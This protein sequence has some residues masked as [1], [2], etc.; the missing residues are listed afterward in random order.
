MKLD[1]IT[2]LAVAVIQGALV[3]ILYGE[4]IH[5]PFLFDDINNITENTSIRVT[6]LT[7]S[8]LFEAAGGSRGIKSRGIA[9][10]SF[11]VNYYFHGTDVAGYHLVNMI[12]HL[13]AGIFLYL[14]LK[15][16][17]DLSLAAHHK[18]DS[19]LIAFFASL[20][21]LVHPLHTNTVTFIVQRMNSLAALFC[22]IAIFLYVQ[23]RTAP[24]TARRYLFFFAALAAWFLALA[25]KPI[26]AP[27]PLI[28]LLYEWY[29]F[30]GLSRAWIKKILPCLAG[31]P[32]LLY[33]VAFW[34]L[35]S[36]PFQAYISGY[37][38]WHFTFWQ[39]LLTEPRVIFRYLSLLLFPL[40]ARLIFDYT[41]DLSLSPLV[42]LTTLPA[43][44][45]LAALF[46]LAAFYAK[47][48]PLLSFALAWF[49]ACLA[50]ETI[51]PTALIFEY[52]TYMPS[53]LFFLFFPVLGLRF[54]R[55]KPLAIAGLILVSLLFSLW[56]WER[57]KVWHSEISLWNDVIK[58]QPLSA[59][60]Y[61]NLGR[62]LSLQGKQK[63][64]IEKL[65]RA[66]ELIEKNKNRFGEESARGT[67]MRAIIHDNLA[68]IYRKAGNYAQAENNARQAILL[69]P[70]LFN[71]HLSLAII[72]EKRGEHRK[73]LAIFEKIAA[74]KYD[75]ADLHNNWGV[76]YFALGEREK[77]VDRFLRAIE[78]DP[79]HGEA[80]YNLGVAYAAMGMYDRANREMLKGMQ[81][82]SR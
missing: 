77:A 68:I 61:G 51:W 35:G 25:S 72:H 4:T 8:A 57:N 58:K 2:F 18:P 59:R 74:Q 32:V 63:E 15:K 43:I 29:F 47:K 81:L 48:E 52:K 76:S 30:Q 75:T 45:G 69:V 3:F 44:L 22:I 21:W 67:G 27:L 78:I 56:T 24:A 80:H 71:S 7:P 11:A 82:Q 26:A 16:T 62:A 33:L 65:N 14:V 53:M 40:P 12:I 6:E 34:S 64:A 5:S 19:R 38:G 46:L 55:I 9:Y 41:F 54:I 10:M 60:A 17:L 28:I 42:P 20:L 79:L 13:L 1:S 49:F 70:T 73:A 66:L 50:L 31:L 39:R 36:E 23:G 37:D